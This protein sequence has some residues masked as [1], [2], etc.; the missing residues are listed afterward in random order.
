MIF[1]APEI[2]GRQRRSFSG[3]IA[4]RPIDPLVSLH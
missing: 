3:S 1:A 2:A 4:F